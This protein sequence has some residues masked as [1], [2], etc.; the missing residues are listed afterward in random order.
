MVKGV[1]EIWKFF[2]SFIKYFVLEVEKLYVF[3]DWNERGVLLCS[4]VISIFKRV[5]WRDFWL[6]FVFEE[7]EWII[8]NV[9]E[10]IGI[11]KL[12]GWV[13]GV[14]MLVNRLI[15]IF[16]FGDFVVE[17]IIVVKCIDE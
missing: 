15:Y 17:W 16:D 11:F 5:V 12:I 6:W 9:E 13:W 2:L 8:L 14:L 3:E 10:E 4:M 7:V 1:N